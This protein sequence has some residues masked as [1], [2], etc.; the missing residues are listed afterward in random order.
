MSSSY[1]RPEFSRIARWRERG[2]VLA[3]S[4]VVRLRSFACACAVVATFS[5]ARDARANGYGL[6]AALW[7]E[8]VGTYMP[9]SA[10]LDATA[11]SNSARANIDGS[12]PPFGFA[13]GF[14][15][16]RAGLD[17]IASDR[18]VIPAFDVGF[19]GIVGSYSDTITS[20]DGSLFRLHPAGT[21]MFDAELLG[22][23]ARFKKRR[24][25]F[26]ATIKPGFAFMAMPAAVADGKT[27]TDVD[28]LT[29]VTVT[30]RASLSACRR[31]DPLERLCLSVT[32]NIYQWGWGNGG[33]V[34][35]RWE[36]GS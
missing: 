9:S 2:K 30:L 3:N 7:I 35:L 27:F 29:G 25:M 15:G 21:M 1:E 31:F 12:T 36:F 5:S 26:E 34:A 16:V 23:G 4:R 11:I 28:A 24:W 18:W 32:P 6:G 8:G 13:T 22:F 33:S 10:T 14:F 19:Y 17:F 20:A